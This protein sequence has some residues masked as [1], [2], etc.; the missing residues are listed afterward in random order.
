M[1]LRAFLPLAAAFALSAAL[2]IP[3][4]S[5][6]KTNL[7]HALAARNRKQQLSSFIVNPF[8]ATT[9]PSHIRK[10]R[11]AACT[12]TCGTLEQASTSPYS[13]ILEPSTNFYISYSTNAAGCMVA[14][15]TCVGGDWVMFQYT[16][17][18]G[19]EPTLGEGNSDVNVIEAQ[20]PCYE[21]GWGAS[22]PG[23]VMDPESFVC[24]GGH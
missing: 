16:T 24:M 2:V 7:R 8:N 10:K 23:E 20:L 3:E 15:L 13:P 1:L 17:V 14:D 19:G 21:Y 18:D 9:P 5:D 6:P 4:S 12:N 11:Q 22:T